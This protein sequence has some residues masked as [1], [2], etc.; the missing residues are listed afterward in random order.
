MKK[1]MERIGLEVK[2]AQQLYFFNFQITHI[3]GRFELYG[4]FHFDLHCLLVG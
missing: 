1:L 3:W 2:K 4:L